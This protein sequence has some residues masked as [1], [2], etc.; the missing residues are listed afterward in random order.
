M[1]KIKDKEKTLKVKREK[2]LVAYKGIAT[3]VLPD[4]SADTLQARREWYD[5][6]KVM[7]FKIYKQNTLPSKVIIQNLKGDNEF[8]NKQKLK[9]FWPYKKC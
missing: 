7:K 3:R 1:E 6:F 2:Q 4:F 5:I 8:T 9:K